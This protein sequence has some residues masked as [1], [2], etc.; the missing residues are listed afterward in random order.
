MTANFSLDIDFRKKKK[1]T[2]EELLY[3]LIPNTHNNARFTMLA[4]NSAKTIDVI[5]I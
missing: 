1:L 5:L 4:N 3:H 2:F